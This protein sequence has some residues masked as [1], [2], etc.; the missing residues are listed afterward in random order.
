VV[1]FTS[2]L[3]AQAKPSFAGKWT[4]QPDPNAAAG[5]GGGRG[6]GMGGGWGQEF[7]ATQDGTTLKIERAGRGGGAPTVE[8][9]TL[10]GAGKNTMTMGARGGGEA[11]TVEIPYTTSWVG[12]NLKI[13]TTQ[14]TTEITRTL[15]LGADGT[16]TIET[17]RPGQDGTPVVTKATYK[18]GA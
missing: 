3:L 7:T 11:Q 9:Y 8:S 4:L 16:L 1:L 15:S 6:R 5:G 17:S 14:N 18:K 10:G 2:G 13:V 12:N